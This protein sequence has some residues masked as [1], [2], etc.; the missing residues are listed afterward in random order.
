MGNTQIKN[1]DSSLDDTI[2][3]P[4]GIIFHN[5]SLGPYFSIKRKPQKNIEKLLD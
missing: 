2:I 3:L 5:G 1:I 4:F